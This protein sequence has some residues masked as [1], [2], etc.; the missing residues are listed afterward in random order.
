MIAM[1]KD[2]DFV[3]CLEPLTVEVIGERRSIAMAAMSKGTIVDIY[4][5]NEKVVA[6]EIEFR[7]DDE[8]IYALATVEAKNIALAFD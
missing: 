5:E 2:G 3:V 8:D 4:Y 6:F 1:P 7:L